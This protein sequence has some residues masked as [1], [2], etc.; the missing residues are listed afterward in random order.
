MLGLSEGVFLGS[1][2]LFIRGGYSR[3]SYSV[4]QYEIAW[5]YIICYWI[6]NSNQVNPQ[7]ICMNEIGLS[8]EK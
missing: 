5:N 8:L 6:L 1:K 4:L 7:H 3:G 2:A